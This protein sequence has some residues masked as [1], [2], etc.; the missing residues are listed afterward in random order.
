MKRTNLRYLFMAAS[1]II[2]F[3]I[4][5]ATSFLSEGTERAKTVNENIE[6]KQQII[7]GYY[8]AWMSYSGY[9]PESIDISKLN[10][11]NYAFANIG[12]DYKI[13]MGYPDKDPENFK[14][15]QEL[16]KINPDLKVLISVGGWNWSVKFSDL[17]A[18]DEN[19]AK[20]A[21]SCVEFVAKYGLDG[22]D[23]DWEYPVGGGLKTNSN[24]P[25]DK[26]NFTLLLKEMREKLNAQELKDNKN[27]LLTIAAGASNYYIE[28]TE[29]DKFQ[30]YLDYVN[31]MTYDIHGPWDTY[32]DFNSPLY[33]NGDESYQYKISIDSSVKA[34]LNAGLPAEKLV[35]GIPFYGYTYNVSKNAND[36]LYQTHTNGKALSYD[37]IKKEYLNNPQY[38]KNFHDESLVPW[39]YN[40]KTFISYDDSQSIALKAKY[41]RERNLGGAMIWE[42]SQ[43]SGGELLNSLYEGLYDGSVLAV[44]DY[45]GH[46][47]EAVIQKWLDMGYITGYPDGTFR[48]E[49]FITRAEFVKIVNNAFGFKET[50]EITFTDVKEGNW[51]FEE[52][53]KAYKEGD[54]I[55][56][57]DTMFAPEDYITR[58]Q[59]AIIMS[60]LLEL[61]GNVKG[62]DSFYDSSQ[63]SGW[64]IGYVGAVAE[65]NLIK[66]YED[67]TFRPQNNIKRAEAVVLLDRVL[68]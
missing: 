40:G 22:V 16:K 31:L 6:K 43:D 42:L 48:P 5:Q 30:N 14:K 28:N 56:V 17:A 19:R 9:T 57:S 1:L 4:G 20:F 51:Y 27:Y 60:R 3:Y 58:E 12:S 47:A 66:G 13:E 61:E 39:L 37:T 29:V 25:E 24:R 62:A 64:A 67:N 35:V 21:D 50:A 49:E 10:N 63:I 23:L 68:K 45:E 2:M 54:I 52:V 38:T 34:W 59:A 44:R 7:I 32:S 65:Y 55:G 46:W 15:F 41:I 26:Q 11:I 33:N 18:T 8:P 36:G 53:Q